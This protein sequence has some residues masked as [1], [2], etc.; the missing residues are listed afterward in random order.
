MHPVRRTLFAL[1][2]VVGCVEPRLA[3]NTVASEPAE[4]RIVVAPAAP[5]AAAPTTTQSGIGA[6]MHVS[7]VVDR[8]DDHHASLRARV[9]RVP[10]LSLPLVLTVTVP[11][12][13]TL[14][15]GNTPVTL[16][17]PSPQGPT[18]YAYELTYAAPPQQDL[19]VAVD[20]A[21]EQMGVHG[22]AWFRF[23]RPEPVAPNALPTG[24]NMIINGR[25][26][27]AAVPA[28]Q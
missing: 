13:A 8:F 28:T 6:P 10:T 24:P 3:P 16:P 2:A 14:A 5:N 22:R 18:E 11:A 21:S 12:G 15:A 20:G 17:P 27:G 25:N 4:Q 23:G 9:E 1:A 26:F 19:L 7:W